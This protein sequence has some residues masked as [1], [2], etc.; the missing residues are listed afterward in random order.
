MLSYSNLILGDSGKV[1]KSLYSL[2]AQTCAVTIKMCKIVLKHLS[3][4][5]VNQ[6]RVFSMSERHG[7]YF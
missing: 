6:C 3:T 2:K 7:L 5:I 1:T 4:E